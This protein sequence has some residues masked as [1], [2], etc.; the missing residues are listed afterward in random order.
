MTKR[1]L[2]ERVVGLVWPS[3]PGHLRE[4]VLATAAFR[5]AESAAFRPAPQAPPHEPRTLR[6][7]IWRTAPVLF[8]IAALIVIGA[9]AGLDMWAQRDLEIE[10]ARLESKYGSFDLKS[11]VPPPVPD[12]DNRALVVRAAADIAVPM[13]G[14]PYH[15]ISYPVPSPAELRAFANANR[16]ALRLLAQIGTRRQSNW[17]VDSLTEQYPRWNAIQ[18]LSDAVYVAARLEIEGGRPDDAGRLIVSGLAIPASFREEPDM[19]AQIVRFHMFSWRQFEAVRLLLN[20]ST[21]SAPV[22]KELA[23]ALAENRTPAPLQLGLLSSM[24]QMNALLARMERGEIDP[25]MAKT[26]YPMTWPQWPSAFLGPAARIGR[27]VVRLARLRA[28]RQMEEV[29]DELAGPR[30]RPATPEPEPPPRWALVD[31]LVARMTT[32]IRDLGDQEDDFASTQAVTELG[33]ALRRFKLEHFEY[34]AD[35][36]A[37]VPNYLDRL[38]IDPFTGALPSY[39]RQGAGFTLQFKGSSPSVRKYRALEWDVKR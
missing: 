17:G 20:D 27:P 29:L 31:R 16:D 8:A 23:W 38:P 28:L 22:L 33:V 7:P 36:S 12:G 32:G 13:A 15:S 21:P 5:T 19:M 1:Q 10:I 11:T 25:R 2:E 3:P 4:R 6:S 14:R 35:L 39:A 37:L 26:L 9:C 18:V 30:P 34:P 24:K